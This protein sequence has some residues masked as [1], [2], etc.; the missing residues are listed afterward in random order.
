MSERSTHSLPTRTRWS[1]AAALL[2]ASTGCKTPTA[3]VEAVRLAP[4][5]LEAVHALVSALLRQGAV[6]DASQAVANARG[7]IDGPSLSCL[8]AQVLL[9]AGQPGPAQLRHLPPAPA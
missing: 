8:E 7:K 1:V 6:G 9:A 3:A 5:S 2:L 4:D